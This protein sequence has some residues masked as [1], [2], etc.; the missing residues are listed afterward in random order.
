MALPTTRPLAEPTVRLFTALDADQA[1]S[2]TTRTGGGQAMRE[3]KGGLGLSGLPDERVDAF[4]A[5]RA[6]DDQ[7]V[8]LTLLG[9]VPVT[10]VVS[11]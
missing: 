4:V 2:S 5:A 6:E 7:I 1:A 3:G 9:A 10:S 8:L 11:V